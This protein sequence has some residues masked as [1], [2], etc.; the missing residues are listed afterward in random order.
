MNLNKSI[1]VIAGPTAVGK[2]ALSIIV[3]KK[4]NCPVIS[5]DSR[6]FFREMS[7]G[8]A[9][10]AV[11]EMQGVQ[12]FF[13]D[14]HSITEEYNVGKY[15]VDVISLLE[16]IFQTH[17]QVILVGGSGL[18][19]DAVCKG[20]DNLPEADYE[21]RN[22][23]N[24]LL[25]LKGIEGLQDLLKELDPA[26][27]NQVDINNPQRIS[28]ALEVC[29]TSGKPY[30]ELRLGKSVKRNFNIIKIGLNTSRELLYSRINARVD[31]MLKN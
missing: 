10:P 25:E 8:T 26:Y 30:S 6:Q 19:V 28:R 18:Y 27:Y 3:A 20:F 2:T 15:E 7:I 14:S 22:K 23:I 16:T 4:L 11:E 21:T 24:T 12:H 9:K 17:D 5:A 1:I 29:I 31:E 13:I